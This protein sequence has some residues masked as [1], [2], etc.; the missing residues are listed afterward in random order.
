MVF[1]S[2]FSRNYKVTVICACLTL[3]VLIP[4]VYWKMTQNQQTNTPEPSELY[5]FRKYDDIVTNATLME[6]WNKTKNLDGIFELSRHG[7]YSV[8]ICPHAYTS[9]GDWYAEWFVVASTLEPSNEGLIYELVLRFNFENFSLIKSY[10][11]VQDF[12][13]TSIENGMKI[14]EDF[15]AQNGGYVDPIEQEFHTN[16]PFMILFVYPRDIGTT[17]I[18]NLNTGKLMIAAIGVWMGHG[19]L[20]YP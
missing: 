3:L 9:G 1:L 8:L 2:W 18:L 4:V 10:T 15:I 14:I 13:L 20:L 19:A 16:Y 12:N 6:V 5:L 11:E 7:N 17:I